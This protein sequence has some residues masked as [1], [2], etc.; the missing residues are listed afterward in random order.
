MSR[1]L[2][3][4][5]ALPS[6]FADIAILIG[7]VLIGVVLLAHGWD[8]LINNGL[9]KTAAGMER[10]GVPLPSL[11]ATFAGV[12]EL[13]GGALLIVGLGTALVA[14]LAVLDMLGAALLVHAGSG[15]FVKDGG[16]ELVGVIGAG[17]LLLAGYGA[18][19]YSLDAVLAKRSAGVVGV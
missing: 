18:G 3:A 12:V 7:R 10:M 15:I 2:A 13:V 6:P 11:S 4:T 19:R 1:L 16:W 14:V 9:G 8:K 5:R 17:A